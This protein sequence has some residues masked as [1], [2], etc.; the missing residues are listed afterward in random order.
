MALDSVAVR[1]GGFRL[2]PGAG[3]AQLPPSF[4]QAPTFV[5]T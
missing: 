5:A 4:N 3:G 2:G 1:S